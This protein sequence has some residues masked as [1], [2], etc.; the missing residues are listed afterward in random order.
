MSFLS[1]GNVLIVVVP[2]IVNK[3]VFD[4]FQPRLST[5]NL[6][7]IQNFVNTLNTLH[8]KANVVNP[9]YEEVTISLK[10]KFRKGFDEIYYQKVLNNDLIK[11]LSP[12]AFDKNAALSFGNSLHR[13]AVINYLEKLD[14]VDYLTDVVLNKQEEKNLV[15]LEPDCPLAI[16]VSAK[17][18]KISLLK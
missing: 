15:N 17:Q 8:V 6:N 7:S 11:L 9:F 12:W 16:I 3:N 2:D 14:Y 10:V 5:A 13:S 18:H 1:P 4:I